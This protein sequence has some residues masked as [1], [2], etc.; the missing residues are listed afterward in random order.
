MYEIGPAALFGPALAN[1]NSQNCDWS[2]KRVP[3]EYQMSNNVPL[4]FLFLSSYS[5]SGTFYCGRC[6]QL[7]LIAEVDQL[8]PYYVIR[9]QEI[10]PRRSWS[11]RGL[12]PLKFLF[13]TD[14]RNI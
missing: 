9:D 3:P 6:L 7:Q 11:K 8:L 13:L 5:L 12:A 14:G 1:W 4:E 2:I 10:P